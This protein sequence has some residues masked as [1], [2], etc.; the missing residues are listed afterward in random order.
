M[1]TTQHDYVP[2]C[3][4][5]E[6]FKRALPPL[7]RLRSPTRPLL[8][9]F[10]DFVYYAWSPVSNE[11]QEGVDKIWHAVR[12]GEVVGRNAGQ[13]GAAGGGDVDV[14]E[15]TKGKG[16]RGDQ[17]AAASTA[18]G[19]AGTAESELSSWRWTGVNTAF[20]CTLTALGLVFTAAQVGSLARSHRKAEERERHEAWR[21]MMLERERVAIRRVET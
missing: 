3:I 21:R 6:L 16:G 7:S 11:V 12:R 4:A 18:A 14:E 2:T 19:Q 17:V 5:D 10:P 8:R 20:A 1:T 15:S 9:V 13:E